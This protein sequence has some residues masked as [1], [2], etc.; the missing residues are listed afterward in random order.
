MRIGIVSSTILTCP[1]MDA[2]GKQ[3]YG[4]LEMLAWQQAKGLG[5]KGHK[6]LLVAPRGSTATKN[7]ELHETTQGEPEELAW[8]YYREKLTA[9]DVICDHSWQKWSVISRMDGTLKCPSLLWLHA[10][11]NTMYG[12]APPIDKPCFVSISKDQAAHV[13]EHLKHEAKV[14]YNGVDTQHYQPLNKPR[15]NRY[16]FLA[17]MSSIKG[18]DIAV[19]V[20]KKCKVGLD[21]IGDDKITGEPDLMKKLQESCALTPGLRYVG[22]QSREQCAM[23]FNTNKA[24]LHP[25]KRF[26]EPFGLA[27]VEAQLCGM[28]VIAW[29]NG[30]MSE[31]VDNGNTGFIVNS[32]EEME[33]LIKEDAVMTIKPEHCREWGMQFSYENMINRVEELCLEAV[34]S[35][36]W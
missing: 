9:F 35:G 2:S 17:R 16:L 31:T 28:P 32:E 24:L 21:L 36:G 10:P 23:W 6:I 4:G 5:E 19:D 8:R 26:R 22:P 14:C 12:S 18:P 15:N 27:P 3:A 11:I 25:N 13:K 7:V 29:R 30:A 33:N 20:A 34:N 1:P